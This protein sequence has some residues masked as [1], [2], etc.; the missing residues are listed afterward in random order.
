MIASPRGWCVLELAYTELLQR[1]V[2]APSGPLSN[3]FLP[4]FFVPQN[5][6]LLPRTVWQAIRDRGNFHDTTKGLDPVTWACMEIE[7][8]L[9][10]EQRMTIG[11]K[12]RAGRDRTFRQSL[13]LSTG[14]RDR[15][16]KFDPQPIPEE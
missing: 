4:L 16:T 15:V 7:R 6:H 12:A 8:F 10:R 14:L 1:S 3:T 5:H 11:L 2:L 13:P 9:K